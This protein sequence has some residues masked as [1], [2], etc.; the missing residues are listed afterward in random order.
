MRAALVS[1]Y[2]KLVTTRMWWVLL[3]I[4]A[5][6]LAF[7]GAVLAFALA[8]AEDLQPE[9][10]TAPVIRGVEAAMATYSSVNFAGY[11]FPL[12]IG[13]LAVTTE[14]RH[15]TITASLLAGP[16]RTRLVLA[17]IISSIPIGVFYGL[18]ATA[19]LVAAGAVVLEIMGDGAF[20]G[21]EA[22]LKVMGFSVLALVIWTIVGVTF[23][24][25]VTNQV[26]AIIIVIAFTQLVEPILRVVAVSVDA[27]SGVGQ[28]L[29]GAAADA[30]I[31]SSYLTALSDTGSGESLSRVEGVVVLL[32]YALVF[33]VIGRLTTFRRDIA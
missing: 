16:N 13:T 32:T 29:P 21:D 33:A 7:I 19:S 2:R 28:Y 17:K 18:A 3:I 20:L 11:V 22:V 27:L 9:N 31:G 8:G 1:E 26:A 14:F 15:Q 12:L 23:G 24:L 4:M 30:I 6:Y 5:V 25:V 10:S